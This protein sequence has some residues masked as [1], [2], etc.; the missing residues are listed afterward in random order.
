M[1]L[2]DT[3]EPS[4]STV[5]PPPNALRWTDEHDPENPT[6]IVGWNATTVSGAA[7]EIGEYF[8]VSDQSF[9]NSFW[10]VTAWTTGAAVAPMI[11]LPIMEDFGVRPGYMISYLIFSIFVI[12]QAVAKSFATMIATRFFA[13]CCAG[14]LQDGTDGIV[15]DLF[16]N[17][18]RRSLPISCYVFALLAGVTIGPVIGGAVNEHLYWRWIFYS[19]LCI[20]FG[21]FPFIFLAMK[22][23]RGPVILRQRTKIASHQQANASEPEKQ[24]YHTNIVQFLKDNIVRPAYLLVTEPVVFFFTLLTALS[25]GIVFVSSQSVTQ[26]FMTLYGW[27]EHQTAYVQAAIVVGEFLGLLICLYQNYLFEKA[28]RPESRTPR[29][30]LPE[31]RLYMSIPGSFIGLAGGLFWYGW[32][33]YSSLHWILPVIGLALTGIGSMVVMQAVMMYLTDA[34]AKYAASASAAACAGENI[35]AAFL[36]LAAQSMYTNLGFQ[37]ASSVL[38]FIAFTLSFAPIVLIFYGETIRKWSPFMSQATYD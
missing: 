18:V 26:V 14:I 3:P 8:G 12:P 17:P 34:Y 7:I 10:P 5:E 15:A 16:P 31:V 19:Q 13:G 36:P 23:T 22:E 32:T 2:D 38:A 11:V 6:F 20:Y 27:P 9:P 37:W 25:Y 1:G 4:E 29:S 35:F 24:Q 33:S 21:S 28:F 30:R